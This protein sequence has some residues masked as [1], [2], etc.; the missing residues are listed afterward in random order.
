MVLGKIEVGGAGLCQPTNISGPEENDTGR[1][2][3]SIRELY[4]PF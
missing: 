1:K 2:N 3:P 4:S